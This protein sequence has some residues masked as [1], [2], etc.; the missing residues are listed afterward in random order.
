M[1]SCMSSPATGI[2]VS[3]EEKAMNREVEKQLKEV[4]GRLRP[5]PGHFPHPGHFL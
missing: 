4:R 5:L 3:E 1:G 2:E